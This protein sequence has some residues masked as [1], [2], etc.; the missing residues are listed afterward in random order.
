MALVVDCSGSIRK[1]N[2]PGEDN[3]EYIIEFMVDIVNSIN[4]GVDETHVAAVSFGR[5][6][7]SNVVLQNLCKLSILSNGQYKNDHLTTDAHHS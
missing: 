3:W 6:I 5:Q 7:Y 4:V 2:E 1:A